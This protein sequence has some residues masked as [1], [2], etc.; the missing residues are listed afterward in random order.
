M[1]MEYEDEFV[2]DSAKGI[3]YSK[4]NYFYNEE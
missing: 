2:I 1:S 4:S 3:S